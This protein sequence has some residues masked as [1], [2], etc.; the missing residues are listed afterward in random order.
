MSHSPRHRPRASVRKGAKSCSCV[1]QPFGPTIFLMA[2]S[3]AL[4]FE[5][6]IAGKL[7]LFCDVIR[8]QNF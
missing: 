7:P 4:S 2:L 8:K 6:V 3:A 1:S 5:W